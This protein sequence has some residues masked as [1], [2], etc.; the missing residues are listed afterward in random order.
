MTGALVPSPARLAD[1]LGERRGLLV[2][3]LGERGQGDL[4][5]AQLR[6]QH[7]HL[8]GR[9][10]RGQDAVESIPRLGVGQRGHIASHPRLIHDT[11]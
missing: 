7:R 8:E 9:P 5:A 3:Q 6:G 10:G 1:P 11:F 4:R 2:D